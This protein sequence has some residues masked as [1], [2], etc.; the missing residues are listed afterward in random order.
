MPK[1]MTSAIFLRKTTTLI[2]AGVNVG[3]IPENA[4]VMSFVSDT[5]IA[6][7]IICRSA[8]STCQAVVIIVGSKSNIAGAIRIARITTIAAVISS[9]FV[10]S[11]SP[12]PPKTRGNSTI[13]LIGNRVTGS[14]KPITRIQMTAQ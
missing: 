9:S 11:T 13:H 4:G 3:S 10:P 2:I 12:T 5:G 8:I 7:L 1:Y 14:T 6:V